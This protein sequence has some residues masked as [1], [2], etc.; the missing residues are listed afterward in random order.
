MSEKHIRQEKATIAKMIRIY[1]HSKHKTKGDNLCE[2]CRKLEEYTHLQTDNC[3]FGTLKP[4]C[5][6]CPVHCY[7]GENREKIKEIMRFS[8]WRMFFLS[9]RAT[10]FHFMNVYRTKKIL[11]KKKIRDII[12]EIKVK[13]K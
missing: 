13:H 1:C 9:P 7:T 4:A 6:K 5:S 11:K 2:M 12:M 10:I 8:G 3:A